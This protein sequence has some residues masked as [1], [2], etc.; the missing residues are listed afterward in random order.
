MI[1]SIITADKNE[2]RSV[3]EAM[4]TVKRYVKGTN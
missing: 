3:S 2:K 4:E 1:N